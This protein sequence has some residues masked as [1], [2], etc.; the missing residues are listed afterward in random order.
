[1]KTI[2]LLNTGANIE[3]KQLCAC[4]QRLRALGLYYKL[5]KTMIPNVDWSL[6]A[7]FV[8]LSPSQTSTIPVALHKEAS[9]GAC[10]GWPVCRSASRQF[11]AHKRVAAANILQ[12]VRDRKSVV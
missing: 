6:F 3:S 9:H 12:C 7:V 10:I 4:L 2:F 8:S 11:G 5:Q 1:M